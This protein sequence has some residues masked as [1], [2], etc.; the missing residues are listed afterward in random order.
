MK[1]AAFIFAAICFAF[2]VN[3]VSSHNAD[4]AMRW[5]ITCGFLLGYGLMLIGVKTED[6]PSND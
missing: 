3:H 5:G 1:I 4:Y 6:D 2:A